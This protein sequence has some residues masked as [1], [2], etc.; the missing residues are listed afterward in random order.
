MKKTLQITGLVGVII[1]LLILGI[2][3]GVMKMDKAATVG[4][5]LFLG[6]TALKTLGHM[7]KR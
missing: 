4:M 2:G 5:V 1:A 6:S 3:V 7:L